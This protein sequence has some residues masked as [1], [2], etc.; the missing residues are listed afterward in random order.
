MAPVGNDT[1]FGFVV[2]GDRGAAW[3]LGIIKIPYHLRYCP[4][5][6]VLLKDWRQGAVLA[7]PPDATA[8]WTARASGIPK[9]KFFLLKRFAN[10]IT[11]VADP[12]FFG[13]SVGARLG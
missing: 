4:D 3:A 5:R 9:K 11:E 8:R 1:A 13:Q 2:Y 6:W 12:R 10:D 7:D